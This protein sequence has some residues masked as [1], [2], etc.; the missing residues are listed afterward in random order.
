MK[1]ASYSPECVECEFS[2]V[3][4]GPVPMQQGFLCRAVRGGYLCIHKTR[5]IPVRIMTTSQAGPSGT[6]RGGRPNFALTEF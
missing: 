4:H 6:G 5:I 3:P 1:L 2:E